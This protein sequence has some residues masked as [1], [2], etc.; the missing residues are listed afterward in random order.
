M[1]E[2]QRRDEDDE[3]FAVLLGVHGVTARRSGI[4]RMMLEIALRL[5]AAP[6]VAELALVTGDRVVPATLLDSIVEQP[7]TSPMPNNALARLRALVAGLPGGAAVRA[8]LVR[9][10]LD[11]AAADLGQRTGQQVL[12]HELNLIARPFSG[13]TV[14]TV[15]D[16]SWRFDAELH[17]SKHVAWIEHRLPQSLAQATRFV[18]ISEFTADE[19]VSRL[20]VD[21][22][23]IDVVPLAASK[24]FYP[25]DA[26][27]AAPV[28]Q[29][30]GLRDGQY[31]LAVST[32]EPR[33]N[34]DRLVTAHGRLPPSLLR[35][36]PLVIAGG[37]GWG[38]T[39]MGDAAEQAQRRGDLR[40]LGHVPDADL[41]ALYARA[42]VCAYPSLYEGFGLP[43]LEAM[44]CGV[45]MVTSSTTA[46]RETAGD[47]ALLVDPL[48]AEA[49]AD[50]LRRVLE[51][52][53]L[54][55]DLRARGPRR[56][57]EFTWDRTIAGM[58]A[59]WR[60]ALAA[61]N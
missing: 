45:P 27:T 25:M 43:V 29:R 15:H 35:D 42:A 40:L 34:F 19:M 33:K 12:Y 26:Q 37:R 48:D 49:L 54:A 44:A 39:L 59:S 56:A 4:G 38:T 58:M 51:D 16:L 8:R 53:A 23:R 20:G 6:N 2:L 24:Q 46:L 11:G 47:A 52:S 5:R 9:R 32:L 18:S 30:F 21:R 31:V 13:T 57:A 22:S 1:S 3:R 50:A 41:V 14:V 60:A 7:A 28:L 17:A 36:V 10:R 61:S 55:Q